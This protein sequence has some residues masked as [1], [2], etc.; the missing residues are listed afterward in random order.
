VNPGN[1]TVGIVGNLTYTWVGQTTDPRALQTSAGGSS[2]IASE[3]TQYPGKG[4][5]INLSVTAGAV[6]KVSLYML[7]WDSTSRIQTVTVLDALTNTVIDTETFSGFHNG[8][9]ASWNIK[10]DVIFR[11][12]PNVFTPVVSGIFFD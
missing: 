12:T 7:D 3:Y 5:T 9:Y 1:T 4:F 8:Q 10:G 2:G 11:I 6:Q